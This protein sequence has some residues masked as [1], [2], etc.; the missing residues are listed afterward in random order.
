MSVRAAS[1]PVYRGTFS[2]DFSAMKTLM[3][4]LSDETA[5]RLGAPAEQRDVSVQRLVQNSIEGSGHLNDNLDKAAQRVLTKHAVF[6]R[7]RA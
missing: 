3:I 1:P 7:R 6:Y 4:K 5:E 2:N